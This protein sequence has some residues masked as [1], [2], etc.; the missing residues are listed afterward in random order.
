MNLHEIA[1]SAINAINPFQTI[2]ITPRGMY[3]VNQYGETTET[4]GTPY[5]VEADIQPVSSED[6]KFI[7]NY[8]QSTIYKSFWVSANAY[9]LNR[10]MA[11]GGDMVV[12]GDKTFYVVHMPE[13]WYET[14]GWTHFVGALQLK[15]NGGQDDDS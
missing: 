9:G 4:S 15:K 10:P 11:K 5:T 8:N 13:G 7:T 2:T 14:C 1:S 3:T 6:I 12:W